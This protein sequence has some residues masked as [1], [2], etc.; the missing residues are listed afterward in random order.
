MHPIPI[1]K[2]PTIPKTGT[3]KFHKINHWAESIR[4]FGHPSGYNAETWETAHK[5]FVKRWMGRMQYNRTGS[6]KMVMRRNDVAEFHRG[7]TSLHPVG[8]KRP[9]KDY[10]VFKAVHGNHGFF[11][12]FYFGQSGFWIHCLDSV[13]FGDEEDND[14]LQP[15]RLEAIERNSDNVITLTI[16]LYTKS[17]P[18]NTTTHFPLD[19][20]CQRYTLIAGP[21]K[22]VKIRPVEDNISVWPLA[23]QPD[24]EDRKNYFYD[25]PWMDIVL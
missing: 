8:S 13:L 9:R 7:S 12:Q 6:I 19:A 17:S 11:N 21:H 24:M 2:P 16:W 15:G 4:E 1:Q 22:L 3:I 10:D 18:P 23:I 14:D 20:V 5:W 25:C